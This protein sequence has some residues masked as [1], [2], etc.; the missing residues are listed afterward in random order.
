MKGRSSAVK[1][2]IL[3]L[4]AAV[5]ALVVWFSHGMRTE[6]NTAAAVKPAPSPVPS[7]QKGI[8]CF[9]RIEPEDGLIQ[10]AAPYVAAQPKVVAELK[11]Q[12]GD[13]VQAG[14]VVAILD[15]RAELEAALAQSEA[16]VAVA[17]RRLEQIKSGAKP[18]DIAAMKNDIARAQLAYQHERQEYDRAVAMGRQLLA[19]QAIE[20]RRV[21]TEDARLQVE[22]AQEKLRSLQHVRETD[23]RT[24]EAEL[25]SA[26][27]D[28]ELARVQM[29]GTIVRSPI[30]G[31]V[32]AINARAGE[33]PGPHG[34][35]TLGKT[36]TMYVVAEVYHTDINRVKVGQHAI[37]KSELLDM[38]LPGTVTRIGNFISRNEL[39]PDDPATFSDERIVRVRIKLE[40]GEPVRRMT[41]E[42]VQVVI[43]P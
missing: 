18:A 4:L 13:A 37:A 42:R 38:E 17:Q 43:T 2:S 29:E 26:I 9:G 21:S 12:E 8:G 39:F 23:V 30:S 5:V 6:A 31:R 14:Q 22:T 15:G 32:M 33:L 35:M 10:V 16:R 40:N 3:I 28:Q 34:L 36:D 41:H 1:A 27:A 19:D 24:I 7:A 11:V 20:A 25:Q